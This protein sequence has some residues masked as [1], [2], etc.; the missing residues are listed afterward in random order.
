M[1]I[2]EYYNCLGMPRPV[3]IGDLLIRLNRE[4]QEE[5]E[6]MRE[7]HKTKPFDYLKEY[8]GLVDE[9]DF[10]IV[11]DENTA[12]LSGEPKERTIYYFLN[13]KLINARTGNSCYRIANILMI[14]DCQ[15]ETV[16]YDIQQGESFYSVSDAGLIYWGKFDK[17]NPK[18]QLLKE[19]GYYYRS[20]EVAYKHIEEIVDFY[21]NKSY[22]PFLENF[23]K[24]EM[25]FSK[26]S[27]GIQEK[28]LK[29]LED[30]KQ[31]KL[32]QIK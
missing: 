23:I 15:I 22:I 13:D 8:Y 2:Q 26:C 16:N 12:L 9:E 32:S 24:N 3:R 5:R 19:K 30:Y 1:N 10:I 31:Y 14:K 4:E 11:D 18:H 7:M 17:N 27:E 6:E 20:H 21:K 25:V 28:V 29:E